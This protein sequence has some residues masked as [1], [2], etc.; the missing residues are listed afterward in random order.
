[1]DAWTKGLD[2]VE[3][4]DEP[5]IKAVLQCYSGLLLVLGIV[6]WVFGIA[7]TEEIIKLNDLSPATD[8]S[9]P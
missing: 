2:E 5:D 7:A 9:N 4:L 1:M 6:N 3:G 8:L